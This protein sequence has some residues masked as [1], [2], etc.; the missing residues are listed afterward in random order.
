MREVQGGIIASA[1][2]IMF[3]SM[4]G[5]LRAM[6]HFISP[7]TG[8]G[9]LSPWVLS[10][11]MPKPRCPQR[12][13]RNLLLHIH[14]SLANEPPP[15]KAPA[16]HSATRE[17]CWLGILFEGW[18]DGFAVA[19]NIAIVGLSL[20]ASGFSGVANCPELGLP[21]MAALV[22]TSQYLRKLGLPKRIPYIGG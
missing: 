13:C 10:A 22:I 7:I 21:M 17:F 1:F 9:P 11:P 6:L 3:F 4:S 18:F 20:Y 12:S 5:L 2:F 8:K 15:G 19:V 16:V 14:S